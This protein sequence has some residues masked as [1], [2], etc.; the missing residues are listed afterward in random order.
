MFSKDSIQKHLRERFY[1][2][3]KA[4]LNFSGVLIDKCKNYYVFADGKVHPADGSNP[5]ALVGDVYIECEN[6]AYLQRLPNANS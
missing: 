6:V 1:V 5:Q 2:T 4:G 3:P